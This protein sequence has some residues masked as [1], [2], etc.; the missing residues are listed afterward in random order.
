[1]ITTHHSHL[2][3]S[4]NLKMAMTTKTKMTTKK[5]MRVA[6]QGQGLEM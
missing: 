1:M 6:G 3:V 4:N 2:N 5:V